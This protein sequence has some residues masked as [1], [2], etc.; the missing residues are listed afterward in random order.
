MS[1]NGEQRYDTNKIINSYIGFYE[2]FILTSLS[3]QNNNTGLKWQ[4]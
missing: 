2:D 3:V 4:K 1:L